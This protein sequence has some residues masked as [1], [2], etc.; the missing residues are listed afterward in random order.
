MKKNKK[1]GSK[2][3]GEKEKSERAVTGERRKKFLKVKWK[4]SHWSQEM[5]QMR[6]RNCKREREKEIK[7]ERE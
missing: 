4:T 5:K 6:G 2:K 7:R 3:E 1:N